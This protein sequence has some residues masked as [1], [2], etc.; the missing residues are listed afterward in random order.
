MCVETVPSTCHAPPDEV[1]KLSA[2]KVERFLVLLGLARIHILPLDKLNGPA[3]KYYRMRH[4][5]YL[6]VC[7][8]HTRFLWIFSSPYN[9]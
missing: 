8:V 5:V 3:M 6:F 9:L 2:S 4:D 1:R 7:H